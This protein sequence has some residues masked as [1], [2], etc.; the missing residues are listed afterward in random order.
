MDLAA[1]DPLKS[2]KAMRTI[3]KSSQKS[4]L[5]FNGPRKKINIKLSHINYDLIKKNK[6]QELA[7][8]KI[9]NQTITICI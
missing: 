4:D 3:N 8:I 7:M 1:A 6:S 9:F 5:K 2:N